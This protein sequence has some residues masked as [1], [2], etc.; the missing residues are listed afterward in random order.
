M[1]VDSVEIE[2][3]ASSLV[4]VCVCTVCTLCVCVCVLCV[5]CVL[6]VCDLSNQLRDRWFRV[7]AAD[8][9]WYKFV[10]GLLQ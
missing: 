4:S 7:L 1:Y 3:E 8:V 5:L 10:P 6:C 9:M 2:R